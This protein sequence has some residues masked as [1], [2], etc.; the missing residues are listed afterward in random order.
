[1]HPRT[2]D[3]LERFAETHRQVGAI[4]NAANWLEYQLEIAVSEL[5][6]TEDLTE[7]QGQRWRSLVERLK[8]LLKDGAVADE[9]AVES[10][11]ELLSRVS[12]A[13]SIRDLVV[14]STWLIT[15][16]TKPGHV[17][18]Q[19]YRS[20]GAERREWHADQLEEVRENLE[21]LESQLSSA[22]RNAVMPPDKRL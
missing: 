16:S 12:A 15:N 21:S 2:P 13:M 10:L 8:E 5:S 20:R 17:T 1:M 11:R 4:C 19:R 14:H 7:T 9:V 22:A 18:G 3:R 6:G